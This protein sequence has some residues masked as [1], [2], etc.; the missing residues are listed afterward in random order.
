MNPDLDEQEGW[1]DFGRIVGGEFGGGFDVDG[2][3]RVVVLTI[4]VSVAGLVLFLV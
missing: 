4:A 3:G 2:Y 1:K